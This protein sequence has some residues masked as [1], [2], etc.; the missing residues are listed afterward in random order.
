MPTTFT[1]PEKPPLPIAETVTVV[2]WPGASDTVAGTAASVKSCW[3]TMTVIGKVAVRP[4]ASPTSVP[5]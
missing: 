1:V 4:P 3:T 2:V 5:V